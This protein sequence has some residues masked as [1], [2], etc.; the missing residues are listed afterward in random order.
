[1]KIRGLRGRDRMLVGFTT[2]CAISAYHHYSCEFKPRSW[3]G[4][5]DTKLCEKFVSELQQVGGFLRVL[6]FPPPIKLTATI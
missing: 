5:L 2:I 4:V 6:R 1:M 3:R